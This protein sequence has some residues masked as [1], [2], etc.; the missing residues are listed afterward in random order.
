M[1]IMMM[2]I[3]IIMMM[4]I[5]PMMIMVF[6]TIMMVFVVAFLSIVMAFVI[7]LVLITVIIRIMIIAIMWKFVDVIM[8]GAR[9]WV[10]SLVIRILTPLLTNRAHG[11]NFIELN[12]DII[13]LT[14]ISPDKYFRYKI[15]VINSILSNFIYY[16]I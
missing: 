14:M 12:K 11:G 10:F 16:I 4:M 9:I 6:L 3:V 15:F 8:T 1:M 2:T 7:A 5:V 13:N